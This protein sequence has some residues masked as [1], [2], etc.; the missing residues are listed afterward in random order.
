MDPV[1]VVI[2]NFDVVKDKKCS[3]DLFPGFP[4]KG[5]REYTLTKNV[6][7]DAVDFSETHI[8]KFFGLTPEQPVMLKYGPVVKLNSVVKDNN[9]KITVIKVDVLPNY[10]QKLKGYLHWVS[11]ENSV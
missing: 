9:G 2:E 8:P 4:E 10:D 6:F 7:I 5:Q 11:Q 3:A 1:N